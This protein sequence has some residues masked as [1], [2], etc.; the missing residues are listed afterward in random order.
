MRR[1]PKETY[2]ERRPVP[3]LAS[4]PS[5]LRQEIEMS[6]DLLAEIFN[7]N[8]TEPVDFAMH[9]V[10]KAVCSRSCIFDRVP[11]SYKDNELIM[12]NELYIVAVVLIL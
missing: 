7:E 12:N 8:F 6:L 4:S 9:D 1:P 3:S 5:I 10:F 11:I 2:A